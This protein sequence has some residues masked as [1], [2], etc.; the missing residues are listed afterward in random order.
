MMGRTAATKWRCPIAL[1]VVLVLLPVALS[2]S[3]AV[4]HHRYR[5]NDRAQDVGTPG[6]ALPRNNGS[7]VEVKQATLG[8]GR[9]GGDPKPTRDEMVNNMHMYGRR[10]RRLRGGEPNGESSSS[11]TLQDFEG[12]INDFQDVI[13][14]LADTSPTEWTGMQWLCLIILLLVVSTLFSC[15]C[16]ACCRPMRPGYGYGSRY[17]GGSGRGCGCLS[18]IFWCFCCFEWCCRDCQD[19]DA[20]CDAVAGSGAYQG[21]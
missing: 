9:A 4:S 17:G 18:D 3:S 7:G 15:I 13:S 21:M 12:S 5:R 8:L 11:R 10:G 14:S 20:C 2:S 1:L 16:G 19:V 6:A